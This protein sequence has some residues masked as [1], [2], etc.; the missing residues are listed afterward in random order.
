MTS[1][2]SIE[3]AKK[4]ETCCE[5][6]QS[7]NLGKRKTIIYVGLV[8]ISKVHIYSPFVVIFLTIIIFVNLMNKYDDK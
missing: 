8:Q 4:F 2:V 5:T 1:R 7:I 6:H 3:K